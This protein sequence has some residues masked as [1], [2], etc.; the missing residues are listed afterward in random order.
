M[1]NANQRETEG[2][3]YTEPF[4]KG[5]LP[6]EYIRRITVNTG[7]D[8]YIAVKILFERGIAESDDDYAKKIICEIEEFL[9]IILTGSDTM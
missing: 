6:G 8:P 7:S 1:C 4:S 9:N 3:V 5:K 2:K